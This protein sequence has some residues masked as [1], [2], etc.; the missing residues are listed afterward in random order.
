MC[1][2]CA[3]CYDGCA[4]TC[5][6]CY[7]GI[8]NDLWKGCKLMCSCCSSVCAV[9]AVVCGFMYAECLLPMCR[10]FKEC[11]DQCCVNMVKAFCEGESCLEK[12]CKC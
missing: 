1:Q 9:C 5:K 12:L 6:N 4:F 2:P 11:C 3:V 8:Q 10:P 7:S